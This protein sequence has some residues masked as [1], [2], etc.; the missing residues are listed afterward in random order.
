M[1]ALLRF[2]TPRLRLC[3]LVAGDVDCLYSL[4]YADP[5]V[6]R[7]SAAASSYEEVCRLHADKVRHNESAEHGGFG[8]WAVLLP[9]TGRL[10]A[11]AHAVDRARSCFAKLPI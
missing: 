1:S 5:V 10:A 3:P 9:A 4:I 11:R 6:R 2:P 7:W 8:Y